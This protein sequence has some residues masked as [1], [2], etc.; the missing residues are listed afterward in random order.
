MYDRIQKK[1]YL[2]TPGTGGS[3]LD[4]DATITHVSN[5]GLVI[6]YQSRA[7]DAV[8]PATNGG[9]N[10]GGNQHVYLAQN[11]CPTDTALDGVPDCLDLCPTD[12]LKT[13][14]GSCG[15][16][17]SEVDSD[18][19]LIPDCIDSCPTDPAKSAVGQCGCGTPDTD[20]DKDTVADCVDACP[21]DN[22]KIAAGF[23]G[24]GVPETDSDGDGSPN[25]VDQ[26]PSNPAKSVV[27]GCACSDLKSSRGVCG[28]NVPDD[29]RN[30]NGVADC[31]DPSSSTQPSNPT[32]QITRVTPDSE[33]ARYQVVAKLQSVSGT[34]SYSVSLKNRR[35]TVNRSGSRPVVVFSNVSSGTYTLEYNMTIGSGATRVTTRTTTVTLKLPGGIQ[36]SRPGGSGVARRRARTATP[37]F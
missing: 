34:V 2:I 30:K 16:G 15:C 29:D 4:A 19:D 17:K 31:L 24:C 6:A 27:S 28:C 13:E 21:A 35:K 14:P 22:T 20:T 33:R 12:L 26:C 23:C 7:M 3:G 9:A 25:C 8:D 11:S 5:N 37:V 32:V 18:K 10:P 1:M 36:S